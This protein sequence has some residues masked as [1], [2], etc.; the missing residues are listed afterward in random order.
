MSSPEVKS[1][2][3]P[4]VLSGIQPTADS[5]HL[6]NLLGALQQWIPLQD[7]F[8]AFYFIPDL[9]AITVAQDP[10]ELRART[11]RGVAQLL[12]LGIDPDRATLFLQSQVPEHAQLA[13]VL[14]CITGFGEASRMTQFKDKSS[15]QGSD[16]TSVGLFTYPVLMAADILLYR[17]Q[18][19]PVGE[20]QRQHLEL[21]RDLAGR[22]NSRFGRAFVVP[23]AQIIKGTSKIYDLQDPTSK[24]SKSG[25]SPAGLINLLDDPRVS[26]KKIKSAVTDNEREIRYDPEYKAGV[27]NLLTIQAGLSGRSVDELVAGYEGKG[28]GDLKS[29]TA[30]VLADYVTPLQARVKEYLAD[31][32]ELDR[33]MA[34]GAHRAR[35]V[36]AQTLATVY[37]K[38][39]FLRS[40]G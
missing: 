13:W 39:G 35:E 17:P 25:P 8:D 24:M 32:A 36:S 33:I 19:V 16:N 12:A 21:A 23:E 27:S 29:D 34:A 3:K 11:K 4:R 2:T 37:D 40:K 14:N 28:Y 9:H 18:R 31:E 15:K 20:D 22:F 26:A 7:D 1:T 10:K 30:E 38:V 5:F 6:G